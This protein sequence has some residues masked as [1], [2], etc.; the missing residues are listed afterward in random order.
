[1]VAMIWTCCNC[2]YVFHHV[3]DVLIQRDVLSGNG[4]LTDDEAKSHF[5]AWAL[6]KSPLF[7]S[8]TIVIIF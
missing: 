3:A 2:E 5:T 7:V 1:M 4:N 8:W 6:M